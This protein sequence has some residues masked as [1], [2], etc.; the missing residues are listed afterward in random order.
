MARI[1]VSY[2]REDGIARAG[3]IYDRLVAR[4]GD[5]Q[6]FMDLGKIAAGA[7]FEQALE[8][9]LA[10]CDVFVAILGEYWLL[11]RKGRRRLDDPADYVR[12]EVKQALARGVRI[13]PVLV[14]RARMPRPEDLPPELS[15]FARRNAIRIGDESFDA[16]MDRLMLDID[17]PNRPPEDTPLSRWQ[18]L[19]D[20]IHL[21]TRAIRTGIAVAILSTVIAWTSVFDLFGLDTRLQSLSLWLSDLI[22]SPQPDPRIRVVTIDEATERAVGRPFDRTWR[23]EHARVL[24]RLSAAGARAIAFDMSFDTPDAADDAFVD[25]IGRARARGTNVYVGSDAPG[26]ATAIRASASGEGLLCVGHRLGY[27]T[28]VPLLA[29]RDLRP[30]A[31]LPV[32]LSLM[33]AFGP[34]RAISL[35]EPG[36][37]V[38]VAEGTRVREI[39]VGLRETL[40]V[41]QPGCPA[42]LAGDETAQLILRLSDL[43]HWRSGAGRVRYEAVLDAT[44]PEVQAWRGGIFLVG[45]ATAGRDRHRVV[46]GVRVQHRL[47]LELQA[48]A[49]ANLLASRQVHPLHWG[50]QLAVMALSVGVA[51]LVHFQPGQPTPR[52]RRVFVAGAILAYLLLVGL[53]CA[54]FDVLLD[55]VYHLAAFGVTLWLLGYLRRTRTS[56]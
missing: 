2:R 17:D 34:V 16:G 45:L 29:V 14:G 30:G 43:S 31:L 22:S 11:S 50:G 8:R 41:S 1:F 40:H 3:R 46:H 44:G 19:R 15:D 21:R 39:A 24:E 5:D 26:V 54:N 51:V 10:A 36:R 38:L 27:A 42:L 4:Y 48:D 18:R 55:C 52:R 28:T 9:E 20:E 47:G 37:R 56:R 33:A 49:V 12:R 23:A 35:D 32:A 7:D 53:L 6:V 25:A 13:L